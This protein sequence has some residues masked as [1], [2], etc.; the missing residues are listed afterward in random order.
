MQYKV[1]AAILNTMMDLKVISSP[2][3]NNWYEWI[4]WPS[5]PWCINQNDNTKTKK[6]LMYS[7]SKA[8]VAILDAIIRITPFRKI[9][10]VMLFCHVCCHIYYYC[11]LKRPTLCCKLT[12][13]A[14]ILD[15]WR[16]LHYNKLGDIFQKTFA[17]KTHAMRT[18]Q[19]YS[20]AYSLKFEAKAAP[21]Y[22]GKKKYPSKM[23]I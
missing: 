13:L 16:I 8:T 1:T 19:A 17:M 6:R 23:K 3:S 12:Y 22:P 15:V 7:T 9:F 18:W 21:H 4:R 5:K 10:L 14:A 11:T 20:I 2:G